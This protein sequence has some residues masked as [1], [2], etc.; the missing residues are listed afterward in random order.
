MEIE[1]FSSYDGQNQLP[2]RA[3]TV[4]EGTGALDEVPWLPTALEKAEA[5]LKYWKERVDELKAAVRAV[6][7]ESEEVTLN[8]KP[9]FTYHYINGFRGEDFKRDH[10]DLYEAYLHPVTK[11]ELDVKTLR[12]A[13]PDVY[14]QYQSRQLRRA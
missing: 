3:V 11:Q 14:R 12:S 13:K 2:S 6:A 5:A 10:P 7:G 4:P 1:L 9:M 8:G